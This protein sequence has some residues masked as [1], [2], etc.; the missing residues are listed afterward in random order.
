MPITTNIPARPADAGNIANGSSPFRAAIPAVI[1]GILLL[2]FASPLIWWGAELAALGGSSYYV[3]AGLGLAA[4]GVLLLLRRAVGGWLYALV[5][6]LTIVWALWESGARFWPLVPRLVAPFALAILIAMPFVWRPLRGWPRQHLPFRRAVVVV[7]SG[8]L[9]SIAGGLGLNAMSS[10]LP[11]APIYRMGMTKAQSPHLAKVADGRDWPVFGNDEGGSR[12]SALNQINASNVGNLQ[13]A[14]QFRVGADTSGKMPVMEVNPLKIG[15]MVYICTAYSDVIA[16]DAETGVQK[17][18]YRSSRSMAYN[19]Y[20]QCRGVAYF[21][22][23][24]SGPCSERIFAGTFDARLVA[25]DANTGQPCADFGTKGSVDLMNGIGQWS[26]GYYFVTSPPVVVHG[27][28]VVD[29]WVKDNQEVGEPSGVIRAFDALTGQLSWAFDVGDESRIGAPPPGKL[30]TPGTPNAWAPMSADEELGMIYVPFG[31]ATPDHMSIHRRP[32][33]EKINS[34][35][36]ALDADTG[37][38]RWSFQTTHRDIWDMDIPAQPTLADVKIKG[39]MRKALIQAT[40]RGEFFVLDRVTGKPLH[41]VREIAVPQGGTVPGERLSRTQPF[42]TGMPSTRGPDPVERTMWGITPIDQLWCRLRF[43]QSRFDGPLTPI[44][45]NTTLLNPSVNGAN[46]WGS[47][48]IDKDRGLMITTG[49]HLVSW[50]R[51]IPRKIA[52]QMGLKPGQFTSDTGHG[53]VAMGGGYAFAQQGLPYAVAYSQVF[54]SPLEVP[55]TEP[56][57][58]TMNAIDLNSGKL[59]W[60]KPFGLASESGP[61]GI[62]SHIPLTIGTPHTGGAISTRGGLTFVG[63]SQDRRLRAYESA[64]G[65][66]LWSYKLP[67]GAMATPSTYYSAK[68]GRQFIV[69][70]VSGHAYIKS[71]PGDYVIAFAL[72]K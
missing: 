39:V 47:V 29:S 17:W 72:A 22:T 66:E 65:R 19:A 38:M 21:R 27:R 70:A 5:L 52:D 55:C 28:V 46:S 18:R 57:F 8:L 71:P 3:L 25:I 53:G 10:P 36:V 4:S 44:G 64:T 68:S 58:G 12:F 67:T 42:S 35:I 54:Q 24:V 37:R 60:T 56:P 16:V 23:G 48:T 62:A 13:V 11:V 51:L 2:L 31:N 63:A 43:K 14:W 9:L 40:K 1:L 7:G 20:G 59:V 69:I 34:A 26:P 45:T 61:L 32:F 33:D 30:Y 49:Q 6:A 50:S 41:E 15:N